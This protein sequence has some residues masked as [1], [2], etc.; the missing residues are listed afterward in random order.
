MTPEERAAKELE[1]ELGFDVVKRHVLG[2]EFYKIRYRDGGEVESDASTFAL[3]SLAL[4]Q[5]VE[6]NKHETEVKALLLEREGLQMELD[7]L[8]KR[9]AAHTATDGEET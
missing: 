2:V 8:R 3:W 6:L 5:R 4:R 9:V 7:E 1:E